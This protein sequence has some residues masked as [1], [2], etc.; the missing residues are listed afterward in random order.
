MANAI[1][2]MEGDLR[3]RGSLSAERFE[4]P[5]GTIGS[6]QFN[7]DEPLEAVKQEHQY[8]QVKDFGSGSP[9]GTLCMHASIGPGTIVEFRALMRTIPGGTGN[10]SVD[11]RKNGVTVLNNPIVIDNTNTASVFEA[12]SFISSAVKDYPDNSLLDIVVTQT[13]VSG[14]NNPGSGLLCQLVVREEAD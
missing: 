5:N 8:N 14:G 12:A 9:V 3:I 6:D 1:N 4:I 2:T 10:T 11:L 7:Q 13:A